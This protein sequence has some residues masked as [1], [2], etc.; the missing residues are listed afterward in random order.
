MKVTR[1]VS[2][3]T[4]IE[5][6]GATVQEVFEALSRLEAVFHGH[7]T[8]GLCGKNNV[9]YTTQE[10]KEANKYHKATCLD[11]GA[12]FRFGIRRS[13]AGVLFPQLKDKDGAVKPNGGWA[14]WQQWNDDN[15]VQ[16]QRH[17]GPPDTNGM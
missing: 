10:D 7:E 1:K 15:S 6:E 16:H 14:R 3:T 9:A 2:A 17:S 12:E 13:P 8:C 5:A 4:V 11:C